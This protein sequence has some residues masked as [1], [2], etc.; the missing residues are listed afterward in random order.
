MVVNRT[1]SLS[2]PELG[3][4]KVRFPQNWGLGGSSARYFSIIEL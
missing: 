2:P 3:T 1:Y 4:L